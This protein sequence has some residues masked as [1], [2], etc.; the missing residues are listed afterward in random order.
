MIP[1]LAYTG[2][3]MKLRK[4]GLVVCIT[5]VVAGVVWANGAHVDKGA[6]R[7][8]HYDSSY[9]D[10]LNG[11]APFGNGFNSCVAFQSLALN[12]GG[13][14]L[15]AD[16][17]VF[18]NNPDDGTSANYEVFRIPFPVQRG[19]KIQLT[20]S[21]PAPHGGFFCDNGSATYA[22]DYPDDPNPIPLTGLICTQGPVPLNPSAYYTETDSGNVATLTFTT[23][24][25]LATGFIYYTTP[26][27]LVNVEEIP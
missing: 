3:E 27:S 2:G 6:S 21:G 15:V 20:F 18:K 14:N 4:T 22:V 19:S 26:G 11:Q 23:A 16:S 24:A 25:P 12:V 1:L 17:F 5:L 8:G 9:S 7:N 10:C 13:R